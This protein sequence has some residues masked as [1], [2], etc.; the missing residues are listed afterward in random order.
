MARFPLDPRGNGKRGDRFLT[1]K[2]K[3]FRRRNGGRSLQP[4]FDDSLSIGMVFRF[5][6][7]FFYLPLLT[8]LPRL[9]CLCRNSEVVICCSLYI[10]ASVFICLRRQQYVSS[11]CHERE[12]LSRARYRFR[13]TAM[14]EANAIF[15]I[16]QPKGGEEG[17]PEACKAI[18]SLVGFCPAGSRARSRFMFCVMLLAGQRVSFLTDF[19]FRNIFSR[20]HG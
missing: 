2:I 8:F 13:R 10:F 15:C 12:K 9:S 17:R 11:H 6:F 7:F 18:W 19:F 14:E 3:P 16:A 20:W 1:R 4:T 5:P